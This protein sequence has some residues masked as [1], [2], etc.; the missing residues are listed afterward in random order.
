[1]YW[2]KNTW[3]SHG[4]TAIRADQSCPSCWNMVT[5]QN[6]ILC[7]KLGEIWLHCKIIILYIPAHHIKYGH[8]DRLVETKLTAIIYFAWPVHTY[9]TGIEQHSRCMT[10]KK[11]IYKQTSDWTPLFVVYMWLLWPILPIGLLCSCLFG[12]S[13]P[14][15]NGKH[16]D[17]V[18]C[19]VE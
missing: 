8:I 11:T 2:C 14:C 6:N 12:P 3:L 13:C 5:V 4:M 16:I 17:L 19:F 1:M 9:I 7:Y 10:S 15:N 18:K